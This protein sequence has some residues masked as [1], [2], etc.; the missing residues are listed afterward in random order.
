MKNQDFANGTGLLVTPEPG[1]VLSD[2]DRDAVIALY[3]RSGVLYFRGFGADVASFERFGNALSHDWMDN[4]G[5]GSYRETAQGS[6]DG[7]TQNVAYVYGVRSQRLLS[8]PLHAD[9]SYV[10]SQPPM[11]MFLCGRPAREGGAGNAR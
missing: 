4:L 5:S 1:E 7:T 2:L 6:G 8:L 3:K 11:M 10:K 9:R